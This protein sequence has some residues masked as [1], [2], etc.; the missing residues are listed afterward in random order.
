MLTIVTVTAV[1]IIA[2]SMIS[3]R[4]VG[5]IYFWRVGRVGGSFYLSKNPAKTVDNM[6]T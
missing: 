2:L 4:R 1:I 3:F 6:A 5:G